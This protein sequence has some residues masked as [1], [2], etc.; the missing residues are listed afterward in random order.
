VAKIFLTVFWDALSFS[1]KEPEA[2]NF[3]FSQSIG[4]WVAGDLPKRVSLNFA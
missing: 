4:F 3:D 1:T 2:G